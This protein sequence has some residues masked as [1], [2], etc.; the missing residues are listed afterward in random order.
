MR[1]DHAK[2]SFVSYNCHGFNQG[3]HYLSDLLCNNDVICIQEHWLGS[4]DSNKLNELNKDFS[5]F[6]SSPVDAVLGRGILRGR[7]FGGLAIFV[8]ATVVKKIKVVCKSDRLIVILMNNVLICNVYMPCDDGE[9]FSCI[10]GSIC[11]YIN[12]RDIMTEHYIVLGDFNCSYMNTNPLWDVFHGFVDS[13]KLLNT[14]C[15]N[16]SDN[17]ITY[18]HATLNSKSW[19][20]YIFVSE[21]L[22]NHV[23]NAQVVD[24]GVNFSDHI[25]VIV[26]IKR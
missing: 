20:D 17:I 6:A 7:P 23:L 14:L 8:R 4:V 26:I 3:S 11:D 9:M 5:V 2:I 24:S 18:R 13:C 25:P 21:T 12:N 22:G 1:M 10:L 19:I 15:N 16:G